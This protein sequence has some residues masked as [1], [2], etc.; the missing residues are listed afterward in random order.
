MWLLPFLSRFGQLAV[1][2]FY[3]FE[4]VGEPVPADGA[5][6]VVANHPNSLID[7]G[8][9]AATARRPV[10]FLA[11]APLFSDPLVGWLIRASGSIPVYRRQDDPGQ[12]ERN[13]E[14]FRAVHGALESGSAV[15]LFPEGRSHSDPSLSEL[16]TG[17]ARIALG[18]VPALGGGISGVADG[19]DVPPQAPLSVAG[20]GRDWQSVGVGRS[21]PSRRR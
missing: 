17:A 13:E 11:K 10:R 14:M 6:L 18:A 7:P 3:R 15:A 16:K 5:V 9:V 19:V 12:L 8:A 1:R 2:T 20:S 21:G 4:V